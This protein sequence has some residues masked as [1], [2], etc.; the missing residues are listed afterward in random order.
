VQCRLCT[1]RTEIPK[2]GEPSTDIL[3]N[4]RGHAKSHNLRDCKQDIY[5]DMAEFQQHMRVWHGAIHSD[6]TN[7]HIMRFIES[8]GEDYM[9]RTW[10]ELQDCRL[11]D[12]KP[13]RAHGVCSVATPM[14]VQRAP[15]EVREKSL[16]VA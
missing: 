8:A 13:S 12:T 10:M 3:L 16:E 15:R 5:T 1:Y 6:G 14:M 11:C 7:W 9:V 2:Y 4:L